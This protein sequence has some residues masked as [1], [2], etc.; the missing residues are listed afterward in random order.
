MRLQSHRA[1]GAEVPGV[2]NKL[3][4]HMMSIGELAKRIGP[5]RRCTHVVSADAI[6][7]LSI[8]LD[9]TYILCLFAARMH[10]RGWPSWM[11]SAPEWFPDPY[12]VAWGLLPVSIFFCGIGLIV[13][14]RNVIDSDG[15]MIRLP[16][17][18]SLSWMFVLLT[19]AFVAIVSPR[20]LFSGYRSWALWTFAGCFVLIAFVFPIHLRSH[21]IR[22][23]YSHG[24]CIKCGYN[25][26]GLPA[27]RCP[28]CGTS[29]APFRV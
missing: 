10:N 8:A 26:A 21:R 15:Q 14:D 13:A 9:I 4:I 24:R 11:R 20:W 17:L 28:E 22:H 23:L 1:D 7:L 6:A 27:P 2:R 25:L 3:C 12:E 19:T 18:C 29:I 5:S 16:L